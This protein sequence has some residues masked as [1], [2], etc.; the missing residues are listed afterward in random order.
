[1]ARVPRASVRSR[2]FD[3]IKYR[4]R[5]TRASTISEQQENEAIL[6]P[7]LE[8]EP[9]H[10]PM[11]S[12][13]GTGRIAATV[14]IIEISD[15][16]DEQDVEKDQGGEE[17]QD[18]EDDL[19]E[20]S[21]AIFEE[22]KPRRTTV[23]CRNSA[24]CKE[25]DLETNDPTAAISTPAQ[26]LRPRKTARTSKPTTRPTKKTTVQKP[27]TR[28]K[29][30]T[31]QSKALKAHKCT[32]A[33]IQPIAQK[34]SK[35]DKIRQKILFEKHIGTNRA[36][37]GYISFDSR[38]AYVADVERM[39]DVEVLYNSGQALAYWT[40]GSCG[41]N[42]LSAAVVWVEQKGWLTRGFKINGAT[43]SSGD[44]ELYALAA[45][46]L[47][48][49]DK[50]KLQNDVKL[51]RIYSDAKSLL[52]SLAKRSPS[53][54]G[55]TI[56]RKYALVVLHE[57][58]EWLEE[59]GVRVE[60]TWVKGH[61][62][63]AGNKLADRVAKQARTLQQNFSSDQY[64]GLV[65]DMNSTA[66]VNEEVDGGIGLVDVTHGPTIRLGH[67]SRNEDMH[68]ET[69]FQQ[70]PPDDI[71][72][73]NT[74][75]TMVGSAERIDKRQK[76][77]KE[78]YRQLT[79]IE[80]R[81]N[82]ILD[83][84]ADKQRQQAQDRQQVE[85]L[86][87]DDS[88]QTDGEVTLVGENDFDQD[89]MTDKGNGPTVGDT[90]SAKANHLTDDSFDY[91]LT[92]PFVDNDQED[93]LLHHS[94]ESK[95]LTLRLSITSRS[96]SIVVLRQ[97]STRLSERRCGLREQQVTR[98]EARQ[99]VAEEKLKILERKQ[100]RLTLDVLTSRTKPTTEFESEQE[101]LGKESKLCGLEAFAA[102]TIQMIV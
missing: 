58:A 102:G 64:S 57:Q 41:N 68:D 73:I 17:G 32:K 93:R 1:M 50:V 23:Q 82:A 91:Y 77:I 99:A 86:Q 9:Q 29:I 37:A 75:P 40:D 80:E 3:S 21:E 20:I 14:E 69:L 96:K 63:S 47:I 10:E 95:I 87:N 51:V 30:K 61:H 8:R 42:G 83:A 66:Q 49:V 79:K 6:E 15:D 7:Q 44:A 85:M 12:S 18:D 72:T 33:N 31:A 88:N 43:G 94:L 92:Q 76:E 62:N 101:I 65:I 11:T 90:I 25:A 35:L 27:T 34:P 53:S 56:S 78:L 2:N 52:Q 89:M 16:E 19:Q 100:S 71:E 22:T 5:S 74:R 28:T 4:L 13:R 97:K 26:N 59:C 54:L 46:M 55:P 38:A 60:L 39:Q 98:L 36:F 24:N 81:K 48:A 67:S 45:A 70:E 84:I